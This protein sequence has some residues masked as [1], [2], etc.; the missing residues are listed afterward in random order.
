[1]RVIIVECLIF[2]IYQELISYFKVIKI[3]QPIKNYYQQELKEIK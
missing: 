2:T 3:Y 1:M